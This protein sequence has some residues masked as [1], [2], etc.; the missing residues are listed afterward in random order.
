MPFGVKAVIAAFPYETVAI[1]D[2]HYQSD[3]QRDDVSWVV[4][5]VIPRAFVRDLEKYLAETAKVPMDNKT[6]FLFEQE[7]GNREY[8]LVSFWDDRATFLSWSRHWGNAI[9][10]NIVRG[11]SIVAAKLLDYR[12]LGITDHVKA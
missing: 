2:G 5:N 1:N 10:K 8:F 4:A 6:A 7:Y 3:A 11:D 12:A 9:P